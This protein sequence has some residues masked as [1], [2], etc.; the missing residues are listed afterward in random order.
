[1]R[2]RQRGC[3]APTWQATINFGDSAERQSTMNDG[4]R[5]SAVPAGTM[6]TTQQSTFKRGRRGTSADSMGYLIYLFCT[7]SWRWWHCW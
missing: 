5:G 4:G 1:L 3:L 2:R 6:A 7:F